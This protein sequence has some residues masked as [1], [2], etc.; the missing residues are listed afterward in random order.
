ME[1][2]DERI[3]GQLLNCVSKS[4]EK[5]FIELYDKLVD[6]L[7]SYESK[8]RNEYPD[9]D[10]SKVYIFECIPDLHRSKG[11]FKRASF[12]DR[13]Y[14]NIPK[15]KANEIDQKIV[16]DIDMLIQLYND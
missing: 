13:Y 2:F 7:K 9:F 16:N 4:K 11:Q 5:K 1:Y 10:I 3:N 14:P 6:R 8:I 15:E 12:V